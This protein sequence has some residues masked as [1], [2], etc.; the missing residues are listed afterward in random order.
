VPT[1]RPTG[2][3]T[4]TGHGLTARRKRRGLP[5]SEPGRTGRAVRRLLTFEFVCLAWVFFRAD[6]LSNGAAVIARTFTGWDKLPSFGWLALL[7]IAVG[8]GLQ[9]SPAA[10]SERLQS[11]VSRWPWVVQGAAFAL[12]LFFIVG[13]LGSEGVTRFI[14]M[15]F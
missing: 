6:S 11:G 14:Y 10:W 13:L 7:A 9:Y 3:R 15:G 1:R 4:L 5:E 2:Q 8:I 12:V